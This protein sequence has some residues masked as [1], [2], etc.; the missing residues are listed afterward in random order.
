M[1]PNSYDRSCDSGYLESRDIIDFELSPRFRERSKSAVKWESRN[2]FKDR[3]YSESDF[4][5]HPPSCKFPSSSSVDA[6][7]FR[8]NCSSSS[9]SECDQQIHIVP[10]RYRAE[11]VTRPVPQIKRFENLKMTNLYRSVDSLNCVREFR[12]GRSVKFSTEAKKP[13]KTVS[14][15]TQTPPL[16]QVLLEMRM[17]RD[18]R[19]ESC[20]FPLNILL[21]QTL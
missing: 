14:I 8:R 20:K 10:S 3:R 1:Y 13:P 17:E 4:Y 16:E 5:N 11:I 12:V 19:G 6:D 18:M 21:E 2:R 15:S 9:G 7:D